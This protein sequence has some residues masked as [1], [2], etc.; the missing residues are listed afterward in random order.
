VAG[1]G[2]TVRAATLPSRSCYP[3]NWLFSIEGLAQLAEVEFHSLAV[4]Q[5]E[6]HGRADHFHDERLGFLL[7]GAASVSHEQLHNCSPIPRSSFANRS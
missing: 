7:T 5:N 4:I 1:V 3:A 2:R 6:E